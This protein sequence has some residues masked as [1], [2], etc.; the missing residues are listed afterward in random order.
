M[1]NKGTVTQQFRIS[2]QEAKRGIK[3][4]NQ[5]V[6]Q[7]NKAVEK[8]KDAQDK[9]AV[10][11]KDLRAE[12]SSTNSMFSLLRNQ[13]VNVTD[14]IANLRADFRG[15]GTNVAAVD[16]S[17][18]RTTQSSLNLRQSLNQTARTADAFQAS[19]AH[20]KMELDKL[21]KS[22]AAENQAVVK[23]THGLKSLGIEVGRVTRAMKLKN[24]TLQDQT[25]KTQTE[26]REVDSLTQTFSTASRI[27]LAQFVHQALN[28][29]LGS[30]TQSIETAAEFHRR[31]GEI[32]AITLVTNGTILQ[33]AKSTREWSAE[34]IALTNNFGI[35]VLEATE[36]L[37]NAISNQVVSAANATQFMTEEIKLAITSSS[38]L[39]Q[40][41]ETTS[42]ILN[43]YKLASTEAGKVNAVL[44]KGVD[45]G[46]FRLDELGSSFA[47]ASVL[48]NLLGIK[49]NE[50][51]GA[52][53]TL[54]RQGL[55]AETASTLLSNVF[56]QLIKPSEALQVVFKKWGVNSGEAA[57]KTFGFVNVMKMLMKEA[58]EA[59]SALADLAEKFQDLRASTG[60]AALG[61]SLNELTQ[62]INEVSN[63]GDEFTTGFNTQMENSGV[64]FRVITEQM[65][66][67]FLTRFGEPALELIVDLEEAFGGT[68]NVMDR[69]AGA[70]AA[71][72][73]TYATL[74][75]IAGLTNQTM[76]GTQIAANGAAGGFLAMS[77]AQ[78]LAT[79][80]MAASRL[81]IAALVV[82]IAAY[83]HHILAFEART[84]AAISVLSSE[85]IALASEAFEELSR[86]I[87]KSSDA[88]S[89]FA[90]KGAQDYN[91]YVA[92]IRAAN[93]TIIAD[94]DKM[95]KAGKKGLIEGLNANLKSVEKT[96][97]VLQ[98]KIEELQNAGKKSKERQQELTLKNQDQQFELGFA[99][100]AG[101]D[102]VNALRS[103]IATLQ[104][105]AIKAQ[106][107]GQQDLADALFGRVDDSVERLKRKFEELKESGEQAL[108]KLQADKERVED[109]RQR[110][111]TFNRNG[112]V[113]Q[114]QIPNNVRNF[115]GAVVNQQEQRI[116]REVAQ[117]EKDLILLEQQ[118]LQISNQRLTS[119]QQL[120]TTLAAQA[121]TE[122]AALDAKRKAF[123]DFES[124]TEK[125]SGFTA[126]DG[127]KALD[128]IIKDIQAKG[129]SAGLT[130]Q[131]ILKFTQ[132]ASKLRLD[133]ARQ[134]AAQE[135]QI[136]LDALQKQ[137]ED[138]LKMQNAVIEDLKKASKERITTEQQAAVEALAVVG[139]IQ[140]ETED[141][142]GRLQ[143]G[144]PLG[145]QTD[146]ERFAN[147]AEA[148]ANAVL[149]LSKS[150]E[151]TTAQ[152]KRLKEAQEGLIATFKVLQEMNPTSNN[153]LD[154][155][156]GPQALPR[157][158]HGQLKPS[159]NEKSFIGQIDDVL[160]KLKAAADLQQ[161]Q[162]Q[163]GK[164]LFQ[165]QQSMKSLDTELKTLTNSV[166]A[167]G[168]S[169]QQA[170]QAGLDAQGRLNTILDG[171]I[172]RLE[173]I[174]KLLQANVQLQPQGGRPNGNA[175]GNV[176]L[177]AFGGPG[178]DRHLTAL[179]AGES[180]MT[181]MATRQ[182]APLL[183]AMNK[184][185]PAFR[186][187]GGNVNIGD[188]HIHTPQGTTDSQMSEIATKLTRMARQGRFSLRG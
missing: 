101:P 104:A 21:T 59:P 169:W 117:A 77:R 140:A 131:E 166:G 17:F 119:E 67:Y 46:R 124:A 174:N 92:K 74:H 134:E 19:T 65:R 41:V 64:K 9:L 34:I 12:M 135:T 62:D 158:Q 98:K 165:V 23:L 76:Y 36:A 16:R 2:V 128:A 26:R 100:L 172:E 149:R 180:V 82:G 103:R 45:L 58:D 99:G 86:K 1:A 110:P 154:A 145:V 173:K 147:E 129:Q 175:N 31:I 122:Q 126:A 37:Y 142:G 144:L 109:F 8:S 10:S 78:Q 160:K 185:Q 148:A 163:G 56:N 106:Q 18:K 51:V 15:L 80:G 132:D 184:Q 39:N 7:Y 153:A 108:E 24:D 72:A 69:L 27:I 162:V 84:K 40:A 155:V 13:V 161:A 114:R 22:N 60:A 88:W 14:D 178:T 179:S 91:A 70:I 111:P 55:Q 38:T 90:L 105:E 181:R 66:N 133:L 118:R 30:M 35:P 97:D 115:N 183:Y 159:A 73:A 125:L 93:N 49:Y 33:T 177:R 141:M 61:Q 188:V 186:A 120:Q 63:A 47:R 170:G 87:D 171:Q 6:G 43:A 107:A 28:S 152:L 121:K 116:S 168:T 89:D 176:N 146:V 113:R 32:Q 137:R 150:G 71:T 164:N 11:T 68:V 50:V 127:S 29:M 25:K 42:T 95:V 53:A 112:T 5:S 81:G 44:F 157:N 138:A 156:R 187:N 48:A 94:F 102:Q 3:D 20:A 79:V 182:Y 167:M 54:T 151:D 143:G 57:I 139:K 123:N 136:K 75:V 130:P 96:I 4:L 83:T 52:M 85:K